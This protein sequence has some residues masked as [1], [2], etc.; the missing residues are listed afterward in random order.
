MGSNFL[1]T[2]LNLKIDPWY[3]EDVELHRTM[4]D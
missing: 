1:G 3:F 4:V 2:I